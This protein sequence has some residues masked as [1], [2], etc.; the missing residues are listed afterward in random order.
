MR[1]SISALQDPVTTCSYVAMLF[2]GESKRLKNSEFKTAA[3]EL[4]DRGSPPT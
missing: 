1:A 3:I 2:A 4:S